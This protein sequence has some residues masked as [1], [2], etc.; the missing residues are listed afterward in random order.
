[1]QARAGMSRFEDTP[2]DTHARPLGRHPGGTPQDALNA[3]KSSRGS[4]GLAMWSSAPLSRRRHDRRYRRRP[5]FSRSQ[6]AST[7][8]RPPD[9][10]ASSNLDMP[11]LACIQRALFVLR[12]QSLPRRSTRYWAASSLRSPDAPK[13]SRG[14]RLRDRAACRDNSRSGRRSRAV[15]NNWRTKSSV[16]QIALYER[17]KIRHLVPLQAR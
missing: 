7:N 8:P 10:R 17:E 5:L 3:L 4:N 14:S 15:S 16:Q 11:A 9:S 1:M 2:A 13:A 6:R 12:V